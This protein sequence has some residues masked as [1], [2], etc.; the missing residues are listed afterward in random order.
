LLYPFA[1]LYSVRASRTWGWSLG[2]SHL[3]VAAGPARHVTAAPFFVYVTNQVLS[4]AATVMDETIT[5]LDSVVGG[6]SDENYA[7]SLDFYRLWFGI[8]QT[9][10]QIPSDQ[11]FDVI[12]NNRRKVTMGNP[13]CCG[14]IYS[15][16]H[17]ILR[18]ASDVES[19]HLLAPYGSG[20]QSRL[21]AKS[22]R[23]FFSGNLSMASGGS[24]QEFYADVNLIAHW[25]NLGY[26]EEVAIRN[27]I[28]QSLVSHPTLHDH[29]A[30]ALF[31]LFK[32][33]GAT[34]GAYADPSAVDRCFDLLKSHIILDPGRGRSGSGYEELERTR[35]VRAPRVVNGERWSKTNFQEIINLRERGWEG[36][37]PPPV[38]TTGESRPAGPNQND[39]TA[40]PVATSLGLPNRDLEPQ[41]PQPPPLE[42]AAVPETD[43]IPASLAVAPA[44][45][46]PSTSIATL[47]DFT[48]ADMSDDEPPIDHEISD[49]SDD[50]LP[51]NP[52]D[53]VPHGTFYFEDGNVEVQCGHT[54]FRVH[55]SVL[56]LHSPV[57]RRMFTQT[58]LAAAETPNGCPRISSSDTAKDFATL[59]KIIYLPGFRRSTH[60]LLNCPTD[61]LSV[62]RFPERNRVPDFS[63]FSSLLR[64]TTKYEMP[65][66]RSQVL[67]VVRDAYPETFE[68]LGPSKPLGESVFS[69]PTP[70]PN[71]VLNLFVQQKLTSALPMAYYMA[72]RRGLDSLMDRN[73][74]RN[75][76]LSPEILHS[77]LGGL[78]ALRE[79]ELNDS[80]NLIFKP[81][82]PHPFS[83][84]NCPLRA[85]GDPAA[86]ETHQ[87]V[88]DRVVGSSR[89]GTK[90]LEVPEFY[91]D[92]GGELQRVGPGICGSCVGRWESGHA[93]LRKKAWA[94]LPDVFGLN[95]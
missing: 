79:V 33:A 72:A 51:I 88:F 17:L 41:I 5:A 65:A 37:P 2:P 54:L 44:T 80:H 85:L 61:R 21:C 62:H 53:A 23:R 38:F 77:A 30:W 83:T 20:L 67:E 24:C 81:N 84:P 60:I 18:F 4:H 39:P 73:L 45:Q 16:T 59:F 78:I 22:L 40:T 74:P 32:L 43:T 75:A 34:F 69:G 26:V 91:E 66:V 36:L 25:A 15:N 3:S 42:P 58:I 49:T 94:M 68:G 10:H 52:T 55:T 19:D 92:Q 71:E 50:E 70:H 6:L 76:T 1:L 86:L 82:V 93:G 95:G 14:L 87:K 90:V 13:S 35:Q 48:I 64:V 7:Q 63:T 89:S 27:H 29:Q 12:W 28:L 47:S 31:I 9:Y 8:G 11:I 57:L 56:S 46:S